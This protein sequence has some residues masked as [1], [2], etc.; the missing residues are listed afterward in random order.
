MGIIVDGDLEARLVSRR[1]S[2]LVFVSYC[3]VTLLYCHSFDPLMIEEFCDVPVF[4]DVFVDVMFEW[5]N[6]NKR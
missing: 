5:L 4:C 2:K 1:G 3:T 6:L